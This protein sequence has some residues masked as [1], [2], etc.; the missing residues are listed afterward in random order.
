MQGLFET[1]STKRGNTWHE[2]FENRQERRICET[3]G[4]KTLCPCKDSAWYCTATV[5]S[6][7]ETQIL[8]FFQDT[9]KDLWQSWPCND[10]F[11][12]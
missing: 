3:Y 9:T 4:V 11:P 12:F 2:A 1:E 10:T 8:Q 5:Q 6:L 7:P